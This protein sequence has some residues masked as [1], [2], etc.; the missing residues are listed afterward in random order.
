[1]KMICAPIAAVV[2]AAAESSPQTYLSIYPDTLPQLGPYKRTGMTEITLNNL[3][4]APNGTDV[5]LSL[6]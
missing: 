3:Q 2:D 1:M 4:A 5:R 6:C